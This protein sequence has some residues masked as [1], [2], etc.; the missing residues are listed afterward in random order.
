MVLYGIIW[1][2]RLAERVSECIFIFYHIFQYIIFY[3]KILSHI[4]YHKM[5][6]DI[7]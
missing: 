5:S 4:N 2:M 7:P 3:K 1:K 6:I